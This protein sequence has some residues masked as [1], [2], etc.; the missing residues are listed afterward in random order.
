MKTLA[1]LRPVLSV[2]ALSLLLSGCVVH[3]RASYREPAPPGSAVVG[4]E[5]VV[6]APAPAVIVEPMTVAPGPGFVWIQG[7]WI[8]HGR[9]EWEH[10]RWARPP[11][12][13]AVWVP[14]RYVNRN[15]AH[16]FVRG[17]WR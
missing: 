5:V 7:G 11:R 3:E 17:G 2:A 12:P 10:A 16:V 6:T 1:L 13:G 8:W 9:W 15:G 4:E 14:H